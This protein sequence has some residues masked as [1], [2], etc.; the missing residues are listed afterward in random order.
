MLSLI[1]LLLQLN[2]IYSSRIDPVTKSTVYPHDA[3]RNDYQ[4]SWNCDWINTNKKTLPKSL[5]NKPYKIT[6]SQVNH[7]HTHGHVT[8]PKI[9]TRRELNYNVPTISA[10]KQ[11]I[12]LDKAL[13]LCA[14]DFYHNLIGRKFY[15]DVL[16][17]HRIFNMWRKNR[18]ISDLITAPRFGKIAADLLG[19]KKV[20]L[21]Q[22]SLFWK[23]AHHNSSAWH[24]DIVAAPFHDNAK[25]LTMWL[26]L[27]QFTDDKMGA[28]RF[29]SESHNDNDGRSLAFSTAFHGTVEDK[30]V[31]TKYT[32]NRA[33]YIDKNQTR[34]RLKLG[35]ASF[36]KGFTMHGSGPNVSNKTRVALAVQW[37]AVDET[38]GTELMS[39]NEWINAAGKTKTDDDLAE[40]NEWLEAVERFGNDENKLEHPYFPI[41]YD[42]NDKSAP[43]NARINVEQFTE[44]RWVWNKRDKKSKHC[45][46]DPTFLNYRND[47]CEVYGKNGP[48]HGQCTKDGSRAYIKCAKSCGVLCESVL[49]KEAEKLDL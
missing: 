40:F 15:H 44:S 3:T 46:D 45:L 29:A 36:H 38:D 5:Q 2:V 20:R 47:N 41:V 18:L 26:P 4:D 19:V 31:R 25:M 35:D 42:E 14:E 37:I 28:L 30:I 10:T 49:V 34:Q 24:Q 39:I 7:F 22:D 43:V 6:T 33:G 23:S 32:I 13:K 8:L 21:Y 27:Q 1:Y 11:T 9:L 12:R 16:P 48:A 17:F